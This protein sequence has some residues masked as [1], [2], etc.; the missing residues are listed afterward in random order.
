MSVQLHPKVQIHTYNPF[1][2]P[3]LK[4]HQQQ[5][6]VM[7]VNHAIVINVNGKEDGPALIT[8]ISTQKQLQTHTHH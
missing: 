8:K 1:Y 7:A 3:L 2:H 6:P 4:I 5:A